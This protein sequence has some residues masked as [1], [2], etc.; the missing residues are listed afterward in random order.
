MMKT[1]KMC[2]S[3]LTSYR[4]SFTDTFFRGERAT[5]REREDTRLNEYWQRESP[6]WPP[7]LYT[8]QTIS[9][10][11]II[12]A[13][14]LITFHQ[15]LKSLMRQHIIILVYII[16]WSAVV[17]GINSTSNAGSNIHEAKPSEISCIT[18]AINP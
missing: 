8:R 3:Q 18:S 14:P 15:L 6:Q 12:P 7:L 11:L 10:I 1:V 9:G 13:S 5:W 2:C 16:A 4:D 17:L